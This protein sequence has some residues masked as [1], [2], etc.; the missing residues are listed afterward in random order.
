ML[1]ATIEDVGDDGKPS[2]LGCVVS[3]RIVLG[4]DV[5]TT[6]PPNVPTTAAEPIGLFRLCPKKAVFKTFFFASVFLLF[7]FQSFVFA[8]VFFFFASADAKNCFTTTTSAE[9]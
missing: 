9:R 2:A 8:S 3:L 5:R 4:G 7:V 6:L 1:S